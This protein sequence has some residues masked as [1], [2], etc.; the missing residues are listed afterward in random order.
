[1]FNDPY[2][3]IQILRGHFFINIDQLF[4]MSCLTKEE[5]LKIIELFEN[6]IIFFLQY[7]NKI[8]SILE[9]VNYKI[10]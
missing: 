8:E 1:M 3:T 2:E 9:Y 7:I 4:Y 10:N 6:F 5:K